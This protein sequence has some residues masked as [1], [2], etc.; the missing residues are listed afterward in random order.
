MSFPDKLR[1]LLTSPIPIHTRHIM[2][3]YGLNLAQIGVRRVNVETRIIPIAIIIRGPNL[4]ANHPPG[5]CKAVYPQKNAPRISP[6]NG[7]S[8][9]NSPSCKL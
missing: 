1:Y 3:R 9:S 5:I 6:C 8:H 7:L 4:S 2:R